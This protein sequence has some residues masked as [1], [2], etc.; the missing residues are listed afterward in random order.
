MIVF[1]SL[2]YRLRLSAKSSTNLLLSK[3]ST[4]VAPVDE[5]VFQGEEGHKMAAWQIHSYGGL[6][7]LQLSKSVRKPSLMNPNDVL[8]QVSA[9]SVNPIDIAMMGSYGHVLLN[10]IR[11]VEKC[12]MNEMEFPL[13]LGR[14]FAGEVVAKGNSVSSELMVGDVVFGV[15]PPHRPGCHAQYVVAHK[16]WIHR[17]PA[18]LNVAEASCLLYAG[19][20]AW[21]ALQITG[22]LLVLPPKGRRVLVLGGSGGVGTL[23]VQMLKAWGAD[24]TTTCSTDAI[25]LVQSLG[26]QSVFDYT[27][28]GVMEAL[29]AGGKYDIILDA[30]GLPETGIPAYLTLLKEW[31]LAKYITLR[32]PML[33]NTDQLGL[34]GGMLRNAAD[35]V[36]PNLTTGALLRGASLRWGY[37]APINA[38]VREISRLAESGQLTPIIDKSMNILELPAAYEKVKNGHLRGKVVLTV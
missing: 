38:G 16:D 32:S 10:T 1:R 20:T 18:N 37:F 13:I 26:V 6:E 31:R 17:K 7:E 23:A 4:E 33:R 12:N 9:T 35:L 3:Y 27:Q 25:P 19:L 21:S 30:A 11:Q 22:E 2:S 24:V 36:L 8:V 28:P 5:N 15:T 34:V 14:D 29:G